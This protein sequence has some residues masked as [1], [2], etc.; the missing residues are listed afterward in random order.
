[1]VG[2]VS[3]LGSWPGTGGGLAFTRDFLQPKY[4]FRFLGLMISIFR[5]QAATVLSP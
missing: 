3:V 2:P 5:F 4:S 1:M